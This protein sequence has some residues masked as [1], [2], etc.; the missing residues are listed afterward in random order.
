MKQHKLSLYNTLSRK[1]EVF[2]PIVSGE[3]KIYT[4]GPT[5]YNYAHIGNFRAYIVAD[6]LRRYLKFKEFKITQI[7]NITDI[8][9]KTIKSS[10]K[11]KISLKEF[12]QKYTKIFFED[13]KT[14]N[15]ENFENYPKATEHIQDMVNI[16]NKLLQ[17]KIAY[18]GEDNCIYYSIKKFPNYGKLSKLN[19]NQLKVGARVKQDEYE[20]ENAQDFALWKSWDKE[21]GDV[22]WEPE[23][24]INGKRTIVKGRPG[25]HI[26]C[27]AMSSKYL[28]KQFDIHTGGVDLIFPHHENEIA[29]SEGAFNKKPWVKY[30]I[31]NE[32]LLVDNKKMAK[33]SGNFYTLRDIIKK[34]YSGYEIKYLLLTAHYRQQFNF[35]FDGLESSKISYQ[36]LKNIIRDLKQE[37]LELKQNTNQEI[38][39]LY[40]TKFEHALDDDLNTPK[41]L[42][43]MWE[44]IRDKEAQGKLKTIEEMDK[45]FGLNLLEDEEQIKIPDEIKQLIDQRQQARKDKN[46]TKA[47]K[48]RNELKQKGIILE[49]T[50]DGIR[51]KKVN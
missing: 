27:S 19:I 9:D 24:F 34:G 50:K 51:W 21:D 30:W 6:I 1:K 41:A 5:V 15:I 43:I 26:E 14:L 16:I 48:I 23:F 3:V 33:S 29:Q 13:I 32:H 47:D 35:T 40:L 42:S 2:E 12:T 44:L 18:L 25:W 45:V 10:Q 8:D 46:F 38:N 11:E 37:K 4:C 39:E 36:R 31:H 7:M 28:G 49:D 20:K 22:F 17:K